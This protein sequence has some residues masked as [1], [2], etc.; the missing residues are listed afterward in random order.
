MSCR[1]FSRRTVVAANPTWK[2]AS[3]GKHPS[4]R[5]WSSSISNLPHLGRIAS[6]VFL[7]V[8]LVLLI[9]PG[10]VLQSLTVRSDYASLGMANQAAGNA[11]SFHKHA[12]VI[13]AK[14]PANATVTIVEFADFEC[15]FCG[16]VA[17]V[18]AEALSA[19]PDKVRFI[20]K[21]DP[22]AIHP[23][24]LLAHEAAL[25]AGAQGRFWEMHDLLFANQVKLTRD[26]LLRY[27][28]QLGL[29]VEIF[30]QALDSHLYRPLVE[31]DSDEAKGLGVTSTPTFFVNGKRLVGFQSLDAL[32]E[33]IRQA[34]NP[35]QPAPSVT[36]GVVNLGPAKEVRVGDAP[37]RGPKQAAVTIIEFSD[38]QCP[39]CANAVP[40][41][42]TL[43][44]QYPDSVRWA[45]KNF[46]LDFHHDSPLAHQAALAAGAQG[47]FWEMHDR[48]FGNQRAIRQ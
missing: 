12:L 42:R 30:R 41:M 29:N 28:G 7:L 25:A 4:S 6:T 34:L 24:S 36:T 43:M 3:I 46:P 22:L 17:P 11:D 9:L 19:Y 20:F 27:A 38:F 45:F 48:I 1:P 31:T 26:D 14:G 33:V 47:K 39:F 8:L 37:V 15:P 21:H 18:L 10:T 2:G 5:Q 32:R 23:H 40:T 16:K 35:V 44:E 13:S